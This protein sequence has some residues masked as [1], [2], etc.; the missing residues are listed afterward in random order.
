MAFSVVFKDVNSIIYKNNRTKI[1]NT[2]HIYYDFYKIS[3]HIQFQRTIVKCNSQDKT[4][5]LPEIVMSLRSAHLIF[6][7]IMYC[8]NGTKYEKEMQIRNI[9]K[10]DKFF[11]FHKKTSIYAYLPEILKCKT[12]KL[13]N[14][15]KLK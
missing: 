8:S 6:Y 9:L 10:N 14:I 7:T 4:H 11:R 5:F 3:F 15:T 2:N 12:N 1:R 13:Y